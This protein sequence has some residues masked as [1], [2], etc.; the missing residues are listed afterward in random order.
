M[1]TEEP[2]EGYKVKTLDLSDMSL[3]EG[4]EV[5]PADLSDM[6]PREGDKQ[7]KSEPERKSEIKFLKRKR[8]RTGLKI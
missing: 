3:P 1:K 7:V 4:C 8:K 5:K 6:S 2:L